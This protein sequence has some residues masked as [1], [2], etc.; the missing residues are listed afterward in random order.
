MRLR[1]KSSDHKLS[2]FFYYSFCLSTWGTESKS[3]DLGRATLGIT[4]DLRKHTRL[5]CRCWLWSSLHSS[6]FRKTPFHSLLP[7]SPP[8]PPGWNGQAGSYRDD[9]QQALSTE[10]ANDLE[11]LLRLENPKRPFSLR[12]K[13]SKRKYRANLQCA[14][15][16]GKQNCI[17]WTPL[18]ISCSFPLYLCYRPRMSIFLWT[19][20]QMPP[21]TM[22]EPSPVL[23]PAKS[24][25]EP[26][27]TAT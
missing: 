6:G 13:S 12:T 11:K 22:P 16:C 7:P 2:T 10:A 24:R 20:L 19:P 15:L 1:S 5:P 26:K 27:L 9:P 14:A 25:D 17:W 4:K 3:P 8:T 21:C 18:L 23:P